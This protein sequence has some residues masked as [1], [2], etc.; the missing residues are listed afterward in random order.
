MMT[1]RDLGCYQRSTVSLKEKHV[2]VHVFVISGFQRRK[3][4]YA[5]VYLVSMLAQ[6]SPD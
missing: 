3:S 2:L 6:V 1:A 5:R 4:V